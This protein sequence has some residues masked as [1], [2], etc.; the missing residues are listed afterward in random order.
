MIMESVV[1]T[2][3][4]KKKRKK[5]LS[6]SA[7]EKK[8]DKVFSEY[9][10]RSH[11]DEGGTVSCVTCRKL[12]FWRDADCGHYIKRQHRSV[13]WDE[14]NVGPQ[15]TSCNHFNGG[16]QD[17]FGWHILDRYGTDVIAELRR[18]KHQV[19]KFTREDL[20]DL[21]ACYKAKLEML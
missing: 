11:A 10:R 20:E 13:R 17:E 8:L 16:R 15:C 3:K 4:M 12:M 21:I 19:M 9:V 2:L 5:L 7:L 1:M 6:L 18:L 14:R